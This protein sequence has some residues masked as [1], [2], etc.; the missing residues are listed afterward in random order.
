MFAVIK[1]GGKQ[2]LVSKGQK[3]KVEKL[4]TGENKEV[5][6]DDVLLYFDDKNFKLGNPIVSGVKVNAEVLSQGRAKKGIVF[7]YKP[8]KRYKK[9]KGHR[10]H[11]TEIQIKKIAV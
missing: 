1:T 10:Q 7:R 3:L 2:Y 4:E 11:Y 8:K 9:K 5:V 6:F